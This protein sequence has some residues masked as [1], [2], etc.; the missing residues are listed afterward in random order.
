LLA[1]LHWSMPW[2]LPLVAAKKMQHVKDYPSLRK[3]RLKFGIGQLSATIIWSL[4]GIG[5]FTVGF[6][7]GAI[8]IFLAAVAHGCLMWAFRTDPKILEM[9]SD[10]QST[11]D[12]LHAGLDCHLPVITSRPTGWG[13]KISC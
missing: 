4:A 9:Y 12:Q 11:P 8:P 5:A 3:P 6:P 10:Y 2:G 1:L 13:K 7:Y